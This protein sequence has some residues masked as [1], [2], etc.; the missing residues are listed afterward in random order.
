MSMVTLATLNAVQWSS[1]HDFDDSR[2]SRSCAESRHSNDLM[3]TCI[4]STCM[5]EIWKLLS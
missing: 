1:E 2:N 4:E 3:S 5:F